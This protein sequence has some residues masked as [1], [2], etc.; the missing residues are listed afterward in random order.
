MPAPERISKKLELILFPSSGAWEVSLATADLH[1]LPCSFTPPPTLS[2][3]HEATYK[4][5]EKKAKGP[6]APGIAPFLSVT[7]RRLVN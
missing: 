3:S 4:Y 5:I 2:K 6:T 1:S 7:Q